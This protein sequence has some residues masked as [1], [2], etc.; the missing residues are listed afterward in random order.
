MSNPSDYGEVDLNDT[1]FSDEDI[2]DL[3]KD[4]IIENSDVS[5]WGGTV[6]A[7]YIGMTSVDTVTKHA[8]DIIAKDE[9]GAIQIVHNL[10]NSI[11]V[12]RYP[13]LDH[14]IV[15]FIR[16]YKHATDKDKTPHLVDVSTSRDWGRMIRSMFIP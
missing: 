15:K 7:T 6:Q 13:K 2:D 4:G 16:K 14:V 1:Y 10:Y 9:D 8:V 12:T 3:L 5:I 11:L